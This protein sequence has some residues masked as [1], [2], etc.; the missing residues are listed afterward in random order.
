MIK[1]FTPV[2]IR[3]TGEK[4]RVWAYLDDLNIIVETA[5]DAKLCTLDDLQFPRRSFNHE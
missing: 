1:K 2:V 5:T 4:G 3:E